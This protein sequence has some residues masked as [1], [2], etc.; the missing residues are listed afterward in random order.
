MPALSH[1]TLTSLLGG[2]LLAGC[3]QHPATRTTTTSATTTPPTS[4]TRA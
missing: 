4:T 2:L 3:A 1:L